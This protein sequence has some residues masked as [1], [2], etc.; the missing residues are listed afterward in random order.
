VLSQALAYFVNKQSDWLRLEVVATP[1]VS[2]GPEIAMKDYEKYIFISPY[3]GV[4]LNPTLKQMDYYDK[5]RIMGF[6]TGNVWVWITYDKDIKTAQDLV[7]KKVFICRP[8]G[9]F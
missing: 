7:G 1:A 9:A 4:I 8:G 6:C 2:A 5:D 3:A